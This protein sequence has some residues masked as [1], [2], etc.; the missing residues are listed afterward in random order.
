MQKG[1][2]VSIKVMDSVAAS[3]SSEK[4]SYVRG[5]LH[6][7]AELKGIDSVVAS[8]ACRT[9]VCVKTSL[10]KYGAGVGFGGKG[11]RRG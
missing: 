11:E 3:L 9:R 1:Y 8:L 4:A 5:S 7:Y 10:G 2:S 6:E